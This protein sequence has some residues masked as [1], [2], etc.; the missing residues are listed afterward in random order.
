MAAQSAKFS[1]CRN[2]NFVQFSSRF[3]TVGNLIKEAE[4]LLVLWVIEKFTPSICGVS[5]SFDMTLDAGVEH[6]V[7]YFSGSA[8]S[9]IIP[10]LTK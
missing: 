7:T 2:C 8:L 6:M 1:Q 9:W 4:Q 10:V 3:A 5:F